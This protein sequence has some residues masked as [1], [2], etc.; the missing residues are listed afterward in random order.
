MGRRQTNPF[1]KMAS[2]YKRKATKNGN[3]FMYMAMWGEEPPKK[4][5]LTKPKAKPLW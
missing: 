3:E 2:D 1:K 5:R 4:R